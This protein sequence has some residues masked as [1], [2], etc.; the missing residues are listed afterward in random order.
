MLFDAIQG[1]FA[2]AHTLAN[3]YQKLADDQAERPCT[4]AYQPT[5]QQP[6][7]PVIL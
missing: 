4:E 5:F 6:G 7:N 1:S 2:M 3:T